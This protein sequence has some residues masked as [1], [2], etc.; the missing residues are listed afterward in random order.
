MAEMMTRVLQKQVLECWYPRAIDD[1]YGGFLTDFSYCWAPD[2]PQDKMIVTQA[3]HLWTT[4]T[5]AAFLNGAAPYSTAAAHGLTFL[6][7]VLC[8]HRQGGFFTRVTRDGTPVPE[9]DHDRLLK[10]AYGQAFA[11]YGL[12]AYYRFS[13]DTAALELAK[14]QFRWLEAHSYDPAFGGYFQFIERDGTPLVAGYG[15]T[16][17]KDQNSTIH[18]LEA[19]TELY[20]AWPDALLR[21]RLAEL[22]CLVRDTLTTRAGY[23]RL[24][25]ARDWTPFSLRHAPPAERGYAL[26]HVSFG[27]DVETACL[28]LEAEAALGM[29][30]VDVTRRVARRMVDHALCYGWD[31]A[32][33][34]FFDAAYYPDEDAPPVVIARTKTWWAQV[35]ALQALL[36]MAD[37]FPGPYQ[38]RFEVLW[39]YVNTYL[40]DAEYG[41]WYWGGLDQDPAQ[42]TRPKG[43]PWKGPYHTTRALLGCIR[44]LQAP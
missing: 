23:L 19:F 31:R 12:A 10:T 33:G 32:V 3:R 6:Q 22:L 5:A 29:P 42:R 25:F 40:I 14:K 26:D 39:D 18:L 35:E 41:G 44:H 37:L 34:G 7:T 21:A 36:R 30:A 13:G 24:F 27:H 1:E 9:P 28:M 11:I 4:A 17:P 16:P 43:E 38:A 15:G 2:G 8:D 20:T